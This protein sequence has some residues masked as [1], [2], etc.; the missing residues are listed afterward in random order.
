MELWVDEEG[1]TRGSFET[2]PKG[3]RIRST[4]Q[5]QRPTQPKPL[6]QLRIPVISVGRRTKANDGS[7]SADCLFL[8]F[9]I[10]SAT[11]KIGPARPLS[12]S[13]LQGERGNR[14]AQ[15]S[16]VG[17]S[18][19]GVRPIHRRRAPRRVGE[20]LEK[21]IASQEI[22][23]ESKSIPAES[24]PGV[25][26]A[27]LAL[28]RFDSRQGHGM[29]LS[30][31]K[32]SHKNVAADQRRREL[33]PWLRGPGT[34]RLDL[35]SERPVSFLRLPLMVLQPEPRHV[36]GNPRDRD[37]RS[38]HPPSATCRSMSCQCRDRIEAKGNWQKR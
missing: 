12:D 15:R 27:F 13:A 29:A 25:A 35:L 11:C 36:Q 30:T 37:A 10:H 31:V 1:A 17:P 18:L 19:L 26:I 7:P 4:N 14:R 16:P 21:S 2:L 22:N 9:K 32:R 24:C 3:S 5:L 38:S 8:V 33:V 23:S 6:G 20:G 34:V 28:R